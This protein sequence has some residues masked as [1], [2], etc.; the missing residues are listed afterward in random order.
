MSRAKQYLK[1]I[2]AKTQS[3]VIV[4]SVQWQGG[5]EQFTLGHSFFY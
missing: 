2:T 4:I 1:T 5:A 3:T